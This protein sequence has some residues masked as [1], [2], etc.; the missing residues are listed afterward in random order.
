MHVIGDKNIDEEGGSIELEQTRARLVECQNE[1][2]RLR[3]Q[4]QQRTQDLESLQKVSCGTSNRPRSELTVIVQ[5]FS[6]FS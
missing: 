2:D 6:L 4:V 1:L 5:I 3:E